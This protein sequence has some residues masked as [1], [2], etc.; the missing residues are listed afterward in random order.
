MAVYLLPFC[1]M[2]SIMRTISRR[3]LGRLHPNSHKEVRASEE[4]T[5]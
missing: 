3:P 5:F 4:V 2:L 1:I